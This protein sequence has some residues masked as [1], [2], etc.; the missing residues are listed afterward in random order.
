MNQS[1]SKEVL[2]RKQQYILL[3]ALAFVGIIFLA[4][5][6]G[7]N[8]NDTVT[9]PQAISEQM[10]GSS[11]AQNDTIAMMER[12][13]AH[14]LSQIRGAGNVSVQITVKSSG[15]KEYAVDTQH[16]NR[17]TKEENA[18]TSK[19]TTDVQE[20]RT[21]VQQ[22]H[23]GTQEALLVEETTPE[24]IGVLI[25]ADGACDA[26]VQEQLLHAVAALLQ[27]PLYQ[28]AVLPGEEAA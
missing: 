16:T 4:I 22:N 28:I 5:G 6:S 15:R 1:W 17:T 21:V 13:L 24:I 7:S 8:G 2:K 19:Y 14:T 23:S 20:Q 10:P 9:M 25:V 11:V 18:D 12:K 27:I 3:G 26:I